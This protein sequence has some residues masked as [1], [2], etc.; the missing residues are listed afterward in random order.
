MFASS[1]NYYSDGKDILVAISSLE[2]TLLAALA[3]KAKKP[4]PTLTAVQQVD[5]DTEILTLR[6]K[7]RES[8]VEVIQKYPI[9]CTLKSIGKVYYYSLN[10]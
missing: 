7:I 10:V 8:Y 9:L 5:K 6:T 3:E 1:D 4:A 2:K